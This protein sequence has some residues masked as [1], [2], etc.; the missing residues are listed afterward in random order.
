[1]IVFRGICSDGMNGYIS[2]AAGDSHAS[3]FKSPVDG[4]E[5]I[6]SNQVM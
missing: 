3:I 2:P 5:D 6:K 4:M 1:M